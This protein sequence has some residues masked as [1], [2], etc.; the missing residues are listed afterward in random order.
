[1]FKIKK[2]SMK[3]REYGKQGYY[4]HEGDIVPEEILAIVLK[5]HKIE[6]IEVNDKYKIVDEIIVDEI[7]EIKPKKVSKKYDAMR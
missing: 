7:K 2:G 6:L 1:M 5:N 3:I 4:L